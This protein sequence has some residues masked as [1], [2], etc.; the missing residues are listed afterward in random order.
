MS[1]IL[2]V[3]MGIF[4]VR[5]TCHST[6]HSINSI[7]SLH[8]TLRY[9]FSFFLKLH[10]VQHI[11]SCSGNEWM[12]SSCH[13]CSNGAC[14]SIVATCPIRQ[15]WVWFDTLIELNSTQIVA[16]SFQLGPASIGRQGK[17]ARKVNMAN[18]QNWPYRRKSCTYCFKGS[19]HMITWPVYVKSFFIGSFLYKLACMCKVHFLKGSFYYIACMSKVHFFIRSFHMIPWPVCVVHFFKEPFHMITWPLC[20]KSSHFT[21]WAQYGILF[22]THTTVIFR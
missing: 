10:I 1:T 19:F 9:H 22:N 12:K 16:L 21:K 13:A 7:V 2:N 11:G 14:G 8:V 17:G 20:V 6:P 4:F 15:S 3:C 18:V 5:G